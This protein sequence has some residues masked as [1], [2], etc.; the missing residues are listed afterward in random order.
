MAQPDVQDEGL[1]EEVGD[2]APQVARV[3]SFDLAQNL[4]QS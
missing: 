2:S 4:V 1:Y 3:I